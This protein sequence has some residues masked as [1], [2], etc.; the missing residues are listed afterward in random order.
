MRRWSGTGRE[1]QSAT[2]DMT[3]IDAHV[4]DLADDVDV[5]VPLESCW[6]ASDVEPLAINLIPIL[7][8]LIVPFLVLRRAVSSNDF[9]K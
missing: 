2:S 5:A 1:S 6:Y 3:Q 8:L 4:D 9:K 7:E